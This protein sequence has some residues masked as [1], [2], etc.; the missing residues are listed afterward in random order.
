MMNQKGQFGEIN[1]I[2]VVG[3]LIVGAVAFIIESRVDVS[4]IYKILAFIIGSVLG[5]FV[6]NKM[7]E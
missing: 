4:F 2:A 6:V 3:G 7:T 1:P 5:Y